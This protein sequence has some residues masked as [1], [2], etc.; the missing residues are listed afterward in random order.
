MTAILILILFAMLGWFVGYKVYAP[1]TVGQIKSGMFVG[2]GVGCIL[3]A[4]V[5]AVSK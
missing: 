2:F 1:S 4:L 3:I 5:M